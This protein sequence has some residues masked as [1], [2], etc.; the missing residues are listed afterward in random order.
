MYTVTWASLIN[1]LENG[2]LRFYYTVYDY[3]QI[4]R[5]YLMSFWALYLCVLLFILYHSYKEI[6]Y[7]LL[8]MKP[9]FQQLALFYE[10]KKQQKC[11]RIL[12]MIHCILWCHF[13]CTWWINK[14]WEETWGFFGYSVRL[15]FLTIDK[16]WT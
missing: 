4:T 9:T 2:D 3:L 6:D 14:W 11:N 10:A 13:H 5:C 12:R 1:L 8:C 15:I 16:H 7:G